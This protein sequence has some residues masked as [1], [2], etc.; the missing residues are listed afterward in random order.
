VHLNR[1]DADNELHVRNAS[2][3]RT[4]EGLEIVT[5]PEALANLLL[6]E[7]SR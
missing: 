7:V 3:L 6:Y 2:W 5:D 4:R 1:F